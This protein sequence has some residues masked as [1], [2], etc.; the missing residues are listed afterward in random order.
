LYQPLLFK[1]PKV[2]EFSNKEEGESG[3]CWGL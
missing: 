2:Q 3:S 1:V